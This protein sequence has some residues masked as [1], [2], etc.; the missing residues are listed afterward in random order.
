MLSVEKNNTIPVRHVGMIIYPGCV[1]LDACG[2]MEVFSFANMT[3][4]IMGLLNQTEQSYFMSFIAEQRGPVITSSGI[5]LHAD[6]GFDDLDTPVDTLMIA[7]APR[8]LDVM[9]DNKMCG[10]LKA[11][12]PNVRRLA[13]ICTG[14][15]VLAESDILNGRRATT[16]WLF[17]N[18]LSS[19]YN[20][21]NVEPDKIFI[22]DGNIYTSGGVTAGMDLA[23]NLVEEDWGSDIA[24]GAA[25]GMLIFMRRPGGQS[26]FSTYVLNEA[27][28]RK[29]FRELQAWIVSNPNSDLSIEHLAERMAMSPRNFSRIFC[30]EV[31]LSPAKFVERVRLEAARNMLVQSD[32]PVEIVAIHCGYSS[33]EQMRRSFQRLFKIT[34]QEYR[35]KFM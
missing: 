35:D 28:T 2:P 19:Q 25:R 27:K 14:A 5:K 32:Q 21:I 20:N 30:Q 13:S 1:M 22:R 24:S 4:Q 29:D 34:P 26:Q 18:Y 11:M 9:K 6:Y 3:L 10:F 12:L 31:G 23:I 8:L 15:L 16:H 17:C 7:G 33:A